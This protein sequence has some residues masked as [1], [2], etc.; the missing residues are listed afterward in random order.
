MRTDLLEEVIQNGEYAYS[1]SGNSDGNLSTSSSSAAGNAS[2][3]KTLTS[4]VKAAYDEMIAKSQ[5]TYDH[6]KQEQHSADSNSDESDRD[7][8]NQ[9]TDSFPYPASPN[10]Q[11]AAGVGATSTS[12]TNTQLPKNVMFD[13]QQNKFLIFQDGEWIDPDS[14]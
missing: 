4:V 1:S 3:G 10:N 11:N 14:L 12:G 13:S 9:R 7:V 5:S 2:S 6:Q 8:D